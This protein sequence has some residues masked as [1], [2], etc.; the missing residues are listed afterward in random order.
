MHSIEDPDDLAATAQE[1]ARNERTYRRFDLVVAMFFLILGLV[2]LEQVWAELPIVRMGQVG[3]GMLPLGVGC[4]LVA[5]SSVLVW[6]NLRA[7]IV[8]PPLAM[9]TLGEGGRVA[10]V[11]AMLALTIVL[12]P[13]LGMLATLALFIL[14][15]LKLVEGRSWLLAVATA[16]LIPLF[17]FASFEA[18]L[19]VALPAGILGLR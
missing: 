11:I 1:V 15:E 16:V 8:V 5:M 19:G 6:Q 4:I 17:I 12:T 10:T 7:T 3:P 18:L 13:V 14:L 9:P 2:A